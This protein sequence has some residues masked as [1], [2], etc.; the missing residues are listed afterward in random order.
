MTVATLI[1]FIG[2]IIQNRYSV[3]MRKSVEKEVGEHE[4]ITHFE[5][6]GLLVR[7]KENSIYLVKIH[8]NKVEDVFE[9]KQSKGVL[10]L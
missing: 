4:V 10:S 1:L 7:T 3:T 5:N 2:G 6:Y 9:I 8:K